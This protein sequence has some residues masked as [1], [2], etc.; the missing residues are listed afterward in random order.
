[1]RRLLIA[2]AAI[3][4]A[5]AGGAWLWITRPHIPP[6]ERGRRLAE[7]E[8]C[9]ACHG[10]GG[11]RGTANP[12]RTDAVVPT[13]EGDLMMYAD[14]PEQIREWIRDG[15]PQAR[16]ESRS[17]QEQRDRGALV[18]PAFG[19][20]LSAR[21]IDDLVAFVSAV[22]GMDTPDDSLARRGL[23]RAQALGCTGCHGAGGRLARRNPGSLKGYVPSWDGADFPELVRDRAEFDEWVESG[24]CDRLDRNPLA[25]FFFDRAVLAM[26]A[27]GD[28]LEP[29]DRDALWAYVGWLRSRP[30]GP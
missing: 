28:R 4:A 7:R 18:M 30:S 22:H 12:G 21:E 11:I 20:R 9:F 8:G 16:A 23:E 10:P 19:D 2:V 13:F 6:A 27:Y 26:P 14:G 25:R 24:V 5:A 15:V 17:W 1:V 3:G 29:G